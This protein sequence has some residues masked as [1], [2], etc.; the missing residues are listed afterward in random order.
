MT[1]TKLQD[2]PEAEEK[3]E[4]STQAA[5]WWS[6]FTRPPARPGTVTVT[7][8]TAAP[9]AA[10]TAA[11]SLQEETGGHTTDSVTE[12][13]EDENQD[14]DGKDDKVVFNTVRFK[15][16]PGL[17]KRKSQIKRRPVADTVG[18]LINVTGHRS[19]CKKGRWILTISFRR[20]CS[21]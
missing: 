9:S 1:F 17:E 19:N 7:T 2:V 12:P 21:H 18:K 8:S 13:G 11:H 10:P 16:V 3:R 14:D 20:Q 4:T 15:P 5:P 6:T